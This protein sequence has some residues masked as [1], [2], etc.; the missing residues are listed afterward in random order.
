MMYERSIAMERAESLATADI[1]FP[2]KEEDGANAVADAI[3]ARN[4][5]K[6][7]MIIVPMI[8]SVRRRLNCK[9]VFC[10]ASDECPMCV[11]YG[12]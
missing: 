9:T 10:S 6:D 3:A 8:T 4:T 1:A 7:F 5:A 2:E 11:S 12:I